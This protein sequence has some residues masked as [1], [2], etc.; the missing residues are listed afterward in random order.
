[1]STHPLNSYVNLV[2]EPGENEFIAIQRTLDSMPCEDSTL[3]IPQKDQVGLYQKPS[4]PKLPL[5]VQVYVGL[6]T[7]VG[8]YIVFRFTQK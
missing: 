7:V 4:K 3:L 2:I 1:M 6:L 5:D 8:L